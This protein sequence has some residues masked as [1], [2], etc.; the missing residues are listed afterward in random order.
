MIIF[1]SSIIP[2]S[3]GKLSNFIEYSVFVSLLNKSFKFISNSPKE[4]ICFEISLH[5]G[6]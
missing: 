2:Y 1:S 3:E 5:T 4:F 6:G